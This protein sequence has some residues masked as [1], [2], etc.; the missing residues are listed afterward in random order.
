MPPIRAIIFDFGNV[1]AFFD[2]A[3]ACQRLATPLGL[4]GPQLLERALAAGLSDLVRDFEVG[5]IAEADFCRRACQ[6]A[7]LDHLHPQEFAA[8]WSDIFTPNP[9]IASLIQRLAQAQI[10]LLLGSNTNPLHARQF[11]RQ[12]ANL[13]DQFDHLVLSYEVGHAKPDPAFY[14]ACIHYAGVP[15]ASCLFIDDLP[16]NVAGAQAAGLHAWLY[17]DPSSL[18][19]H[20][21]QLGLLSHP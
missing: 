5:R 2:Y 7:G 1:I 19:L 3:H 15:P 10:P 17:R 20:L 6:L 12:F 9:P 13:L 21:Q 11:R 4:T 8:A 16:E 18:T 14:H